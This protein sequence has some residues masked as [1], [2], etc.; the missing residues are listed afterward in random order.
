MTESPRPR[1]SYEEFW[2]EPTPEAEAAQKK[3][4]ELYASLPR[5]PLVSE[6]RFVFLSRPRI[7]RI[8]ERQKIP[9]GAFTI[10]EDYEE[11]SVADLLRETLTERLLRR[12][13]I[14]GSGSAFCAG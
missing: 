1:R 14:K 10:P 7:I 11:K 4:L 2:G 13:G 12:F 9:E 8:E 5:L 6:E 3:R